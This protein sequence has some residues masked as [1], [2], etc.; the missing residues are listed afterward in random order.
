[1]SSGDKINLAIFASGAGSNANQICIYFKEHPSISVRL[2]VS[3]KKEAGVFRI[4]EQHGI[5]TA[6]IPKSDWDNENKII[7][8]LHSKDISH[9]VLA[10]FLLLCPKWLVSHYR[11][12]IINIH[13]ALLPKYG[14][15]GMYGMKVHQKVK[16][17]G[18]SVSGITIH[19]VDEHYDEGDVIFQEKV[20]VD[21][22]DSAGEIAEKVLRLEH[23]HYP[24]VIERWTKE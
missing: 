5:E 8:L 19:N 2:I 23:Y 17:D 16:D 11:G 13:P 7:T 14:G 22:N 15:K 10:G 18:E 12:R 24:R 20:F 9:I 4:A 1:M 21:E 3:N 6:Y